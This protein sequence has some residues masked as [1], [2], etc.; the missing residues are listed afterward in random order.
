[1]AAIFAGSGHSRVFPQPDDSKLFSL[2]A[3]CK[4]ARTTASCIVVFA[5]SRNQPPTT[6]SFGSQAIPNPWK[7]DDPMLEIDSL[8]PGWRQ[9]SGVPAPVLMIARDQNQIV[10]V[11]LIGRP[12]APGDEDAIYT[13]I[14]NL[15][16]VQAAHQA[17]LTQMDSVAGPLT[18][19]DNKVAN[20]LGAKGQQRKDAIAAIEDPCRQL[21]LPYTPGQ[22]RKLKRDIEERLKEET[23]RRAAEEREWKD[24]ERAIKA[25]PAGSGQPTPGVFRF[26]VRSGR[27]EAIIGL[28]EVEKNEKK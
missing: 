26:L 7:A 22:E 4:Y 11:S 19:L 17:I 8:T 18:N 24:T 15:G 9:V 14:S 20:S 5:S 16:G 2:N 23:N 10:R 25:L 13:D 21:N 1:M 3:R 28:L 12:E 6:S 27:T